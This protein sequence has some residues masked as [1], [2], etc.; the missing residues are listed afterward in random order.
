MKPQGTISI[1]VDTLHSIFKGQNL[2]PNAKYDWSEFEEGLTNILGFFEERNI[3][4]TLFCVGYDFTINKNQEL[5]R[6]VHTRGHEI[7][8]HTM[9]HTQGL[10]LLPL[11]NKEK[12]IA[13]FEEICNSTIGEKPIGFRAPGWNIDEE[14]LQILRRRSYRYDSSIFP[15]FLMPI[16]KFMHY[17]AMKSRPYPDRTTMGKLSYMFCPIEPYRTDIS[18]FHKGENGIREFPISV[19]PRLR[20]PLFATMLFKL[21]A[22]NFQKT[23]DAIKQNGKPIQFMLHLSDFVD[24]SKKCYARQISNLKGVYISQSITMDYRKKMDLIKRAFDIMMKDYEFKTYRER[25]GQ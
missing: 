3:K 19:S 18:S 14:I 22:E 13:E 24:F 9:N 20:F 2:A 7:A 25:C 11:V 12:E 1:D 15:T 21:G 4:A 17:F 10:R 5:I 6:N 23:F 8:N 16:M